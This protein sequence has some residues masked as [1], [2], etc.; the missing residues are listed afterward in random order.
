M[1]EKKQ[2]LSIFILSLMIR[3]FFVLTVVHPPLGNDAK[4]YDV[5]GY[6]LSQGRGFINSEG[7]PT[8][9]R[10]PI[11]PL[12]LGGIYYIS[13]HNLLAVRLVQAFLSATISIFVYFITKMLFRK[14]TAILSGYL[15]CLYLPFVANAIEVT[16]ETLFT[17]FLVL[18]ILVAISEIRINKFLPVGIIFGLSL[19][20]RPF[21]IFFIPLLLYWIF[22]CSESTKLKAATLFAIGLLLVIIPWTY[23]NYDKLDSFIPLSSGGGLALY[24][25]YVVPPKGFGFN[26][27]DKVSEGFYG[28]RDETERNR[29]LIN[30]TVQHIKENPLQSIK[31]TIN[32][33]LLFIYP[34]DGYWYNI[35]FGSKYNMFWGNILVF[36][37]FGIYFGFSNYDTRKKLIYFLFLSFFV[38]VIIFIGIPRYRL[39]VEPFLISFAALG[40]IQMYSKCLFGFYSVVVVNIGLFSIF[41]Y[42]N[43]TFFFDYLKSL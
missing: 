19:L 41:R 42:F 6:N 20:T 3:V 40:I 33:I 2:I 9:F 27:L 12:L 17:F 5:L 28:L 1:S 18:G 37:I 34:F 16:T 38:G 22:V 43:L 11:Y 24:N 8:A 35:P 10:P 30:K 15:S 29:Y 36:S 7:E 32:K 23:R 39:P 14:K 31:L 13:G 21:I 26:S 25:A 4:D